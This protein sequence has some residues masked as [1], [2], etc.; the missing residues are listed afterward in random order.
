MSRG[1]HLPAVA[2]VGLLPKA[3]IVQRWVRAETN[4][5]L[6]AE[7]LR[8]ARAAGEAHRENSR[9]GNSPHDFCTKVLLFLSAFCLVPQVRAAPPGANLGISGRCRPET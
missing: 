9:I 3:A 1:L 7:G 6:S 2:N 8:V 4:Q 5:F